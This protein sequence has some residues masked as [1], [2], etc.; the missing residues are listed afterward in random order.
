MRKSVIIGLLL[1]LA[2]T[3]CTTPTGNVV[4]DQQVVKIGA[5][6]PMTGDVAFIGEGVVRGLELALDD[7]ETTRYRYELIVEDDQLDPKKTASAAQKLITVD[8]VDVLVSASSGTGNV[9]TP[10]AESAEVVHFGIA[11]DPAVAN[12]Q[13]NFIHWTPPEE[14]A[15][16]W[17][18][19]AQ[20]RGYERIALL[21]VQQQGA[22]VIIEAVIEHMEDAGMEPVFVEYFNFGEKNFETLLLK[23]EQTNPDMYLLMA[24]S[25]ELD[26]LHKQLRQKGITAEISGIESFE[27][28]SDIAQ[29]E[30]EWYVNAGEPVG[31][32]IQHHENAYD[33]LPGFAAGN[34]YDII[35]LLVEVYEDHPVKPDTATIAADLHALEGFTGPLGPLEVDDR[36]IIVSKAVVKT[37]KDGVPVVLQ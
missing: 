37:I 16:E 17:V 18:A 25:P 34:S 29:F 35:N 26:I 12:G 6:L 1:L 21:G 3:A 9:V 28:T 15:K 30:G 27:I 31:E 13:Y 23:A 5:V 7:L 14:E 2:F 22:V 19:E 33:A 8:D 10:I 24:F 32:F 4:G 36:G 11:S 20:R